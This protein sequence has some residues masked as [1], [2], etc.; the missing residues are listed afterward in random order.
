MLGT[1][2]NAGGNMVKGVFFCELNLIFPI[3][4]I[5]DLVLGHIFQDIPLET[6]VM[7]R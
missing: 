4:C 1:K 6:S 7:Q 5:V 3:T 2:S